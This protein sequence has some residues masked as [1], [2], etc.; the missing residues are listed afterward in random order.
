L[1]SSFFSSPDV[2][3]HASDS[4]LIYHA[5]EYG[6]PHPT[7]DDESDEEEDGNFLSAEEAESTAYYEE[8]INPFA[9]I[10]NLPPLTPEMRARSPALP[11]KTRSTPEFSLVLD[12][13]SQFGRSWGVSK[14]SV[15]CECDKRKTIYVKMDVFWCPRVT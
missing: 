10:K 6:H 15:D 14:S 1:S 13:V 9:F 2:P 11:L 5:T 12:L 7:P 4:S 8:Y 3:N